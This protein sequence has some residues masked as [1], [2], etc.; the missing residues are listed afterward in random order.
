M[1]EPTGRLGDILQRVLS[2][3][4]QPATTTPARAAA[5]HPSWRDQ[6]VLSQFPDLDPELIPDG[7]K[8]AYDIAL[9]ANKWPLYVFGDAG[10]GKSFAAGYVAAVVASRGFRC[11]FV[12]TAACLSCISKSAAADDGMASYLG[13]MVYGSTFKR[14]LLEAGFVVLDDLGTRSPSA[15]QYDILRDVIDGR[16]QMP[17]LITSN[18]KPDEIEKVY[19]GRIGSRL[20]EGVWYEFKGQDRRLDK[21]VYIT[22]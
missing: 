1:T 3:T 2:R 10:R 13:S 12:N 6:P 11:E 5:S 18:L 4:T 15:A 9:N 8:R 16:F 14:R 20:L 22:D 19:D 21:S 17:T 7:F